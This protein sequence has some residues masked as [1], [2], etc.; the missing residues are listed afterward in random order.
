MYMSNNIGTN[1]ENVSDIWGA[2]GQREALCQV[3]EVCRKGLSLETNV[4][5]DRLSF[6]S[7]IKAG[8]DQSGILSI[9][10]TLRDDSVIVVRLE[11]VRGHNTMRVPSSPFFRHLSDLGNRVCLCAPDEQKNGMVSLF[12]EID[13]KAVPMSMTREASLLSEIKR[14]HEFSKLLQAELP[15]IHDDSEIENIYKEFSEALEPVRPFREKTLIYHPELLSWSQEVYQFLSS[16][17]SVAVVSPFSVI[18]DFALSMIARVFVDSGNT[19]GQLRL[20]AINATGLLDIARK[21]PGSLVVKAVCMR[22]GTNPYELGNE[23]RLLLTA[24]ASENKPVIFTGT[25]EQLQA[26]FSGGQGASNDPLIPIILHVP[27]ITI[28]RLVPFAIQSCGRLAGGLSQKTENDLIEKT[29]EI[30]RDLSPVEQKRLLPI[31]SK[32][33]IHMWSKGTTEIVSP[34]KMFASKVCSLSETLGGLSACPR[35]ERTPEVQE[36]FT[37]TMTDPSL[38]SYFQEHLLA[39]DEALEQLV[40]RL[41]MEALTRPL[42]QPIRY[43]A[44]GTPATGKSE[45]A[46][47][48]ARRLNI[49]YVNIDAASMPDYHTA[50]SQLLGAGRGIVM[51]YQAG[52]LEQVAKHHTGAVV[53]VSDLDH[54]VPSVRSVLADLFLQ[55]LETGE[56]QSATGSMF[57]CAN[58]IFVFTMNLP[59]GM[60][61]EVRKSLGFNNSPSRQDVRRKVIREIK[62]MLSGAFLSRIG[63]PI[64]FEPLDGDMLAIVLERSIKRA[65]ISAA[66]RLHVPILEIMLEKDA[67][68]HLISSLD[69]SI[70]SFGARAILEQGRSMAAKAFVEF[71]KNNKDFNEKLLFV[72]V[73][74]EGKLVLNTR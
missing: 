34:V 64:L 30:L 10:G 49:P 40:F 36:R 16:S 28:E 2:E 39:Q 6:N 69:R 35:S 20:P 15:V 31:I 55:V 5:F 51:S 43:C 29:L 63:T 42:H 59:G 72:S 60:D 4:A 1:R 58:I 56:A 25:F 62:M 65:I 53:E 22:F 52:R 9:S 68:M 57:S 24:L 23:M 21:A 7:A 38:L 70:S 50:A 33:I 67:G 32:R 17:A 12:I 37:E 27:D 11:V 71:Y 61:E 54:A 74:S 47:L 46:I 14:I 13:V 48:L 66:E 8:K 19:L 3:A 26:V 44:Q 73:N 18:L 41:I 45:S